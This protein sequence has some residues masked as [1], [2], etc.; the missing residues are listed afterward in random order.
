MEVEFLKEIGTSFDEE[1]K[2]LEIQIK[3]DDNSY[4]EFWLSSD[5]GL[6][7]IMKDTALNI[8][9]EVSNEEFVYIVLGFGRRIERSMER[10][11]KL[12]REGEE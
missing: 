3:E 10:L 12:S 11:R 8:Q 5:A 9:D 1:V 4:Y 6:A 7:S 2:R